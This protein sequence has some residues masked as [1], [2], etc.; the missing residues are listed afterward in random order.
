MIICKL[1]IHSYGPTHFAGGGGSGNVSAY[2]NYRATCQH[3]GKITQWTEYWK[4]SQ[5]VV[6][7]SSKETHD[8]WNNTQNPKKETPNVPV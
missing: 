8:A 2:A 4:P 3:C 6:N 7:S 1:G 5:D